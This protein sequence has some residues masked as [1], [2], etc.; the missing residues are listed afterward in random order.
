MKKVIVS[1]LLATF[2]SFVMAGGDIV[3]NPDEIMPE[4][5]CR[6]NDVYVDYRG[7]LMWQDAPYGDIE[8]GAYKN[9]KSAGKAG[10][11][12]YANNYCSEL[13]YAGHSDWRLP[14]VKELSELYMKKNKL[15]NNE[16]EDFWTSTPSKGD[17]YF[18]IYGI[19][20]GFP[21]KRKKSD[22][23]YIRCVRCL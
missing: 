10:K 1:V 3:P 11:W 4:A 19:V 13:D 14:K 8:D 16:T 18:V 20:E 23:H 15:K 2:G 6:A 5:S 9:N 7:K 22:S 17:E 12:Q 21:Y